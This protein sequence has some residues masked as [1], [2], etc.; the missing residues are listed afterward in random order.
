[1]INVNQK[2]KDTY[3]DYIHST[4]EINMNREM[5]NFKNYLNSLSEGKSDFISADDKLL[6]LME[7]LSGNFF[8]SDFFRAVKAYGEKNTD[9][10]YSQKYETICSESSDGEMLLEMIID[11][12]KNLV[13]KSISVKEPINSRH[14]VSDFLV[15]S[16]INDLFLYEPNM[17]PDTVLGRMYTGDM[18]LRY[19]ENLVLDM[20]VKL[21]VNPD[22]ASNMQGLVLKAK[23][24]DGVL[25]L[26]KNVDIR[27][28]RDSVLDLSVYDA[29]FDWLEV[30][31]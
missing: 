12:D 9:I 18:L 11:K 29:N 24:R 2:M 4:S 13:L 17:F 3:F 20:K 10:F 30:I 25:D 5:I 26:A 21:T 7:K 8:S 6:L 31:Y 23:Y 14:T 16:K 15:F 27:E 28:R 22:S 1:M 19:T